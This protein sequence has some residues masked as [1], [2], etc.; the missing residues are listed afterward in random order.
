MNVRV[1]E[2]RHWADFFA[3]A[4]V[5]VRVRASHFFL[6]IFLSPSNDDG[7]CFEKKS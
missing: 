5:C 1:D 2:R 6:P 7:T 4:S 3:H